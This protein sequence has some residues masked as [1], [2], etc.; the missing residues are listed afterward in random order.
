MLRPLRLHLPIALGAVA[1][2]VGLAACSGDAAEAEQP[3]AAPETLTQEQAPAPPPP[4]PEVAIRVVDGDTSRPV[5]GARVVAAGGA[6][7]AGTDGT[8][9]LVAPER[10][11]LKVTVTARGYS[12]TTLRVDSRG[13]RASR[14]T[15]FRPALQW[16]QYGANPA[17]TQVHPTLKLRP[18]F[19][20]VWHRNVVGMLEY[21]AVV[22]EGV[23]YVNTMRGWTRAISMK[24]GR[25]LWRKRVGTL[26]AS[27]P[28]VDT[29][30]G[31]LVVTT[32]SP[33]RVTVLDLETG[34]VRWRFDSGMAEPSPVIRNDVAYLGSTTGNVYALDLERRR[35]RWT[36][37][38]GVKITG[39][40]ALAGNRIY[41]GDYA[42]RVFALNA[43]TG[44]RIWTGSAGTRVY[45]TA[46]V[47]RGRVF[48][49]SVFSGLSA[50]SA[51]TGRLLWRV[52]VGSYL[53]GSPAAYKGRVYFGTHGGS[54]YAVNASTGRV[55]WTR[56]AGGRVSG[57]AQVVGDLVYASSLEGRISAWNPRTGRR[58]W[59]FPEG[60][61]VPISG[62][63]ERLLLHGR[64]DIWAVEEKRRR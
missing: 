40:P 48:V 44:R 19:R 49:P 16:P 18:P 59:T 64:H 15:I 52:P 57:A 36:F 50:L 60:M 43:R 30:R 55:L 12:P 27:S 54:V 9:R 3:R 45:G 26:M 1:L 46:A 14:V 33:G 23:A 5:R 63:G 32:M 24:N 22:W 29:E 20:R 41:V 34:R 47:L 7:R 8:A 56:S 31:S 38:G 35:L 25:I 21:P 61:Y 37:H 53:Y 62:S 11:R 4:P 6:V 42:G 58:V 10:R 28:A 51:R 2:A 13:G 17:R 39:S